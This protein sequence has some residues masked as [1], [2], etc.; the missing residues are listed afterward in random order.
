MARGRPI[1]PTV[2]L[3]IPKR[4][5]QALFRTQLFE[6]GFRVRGFERLSEA[7]AAL[8]RERRPPAAFVLD[9]P[10]AGDAA[11][12]R[13][14]PETIAVLLCLGPF[15][16]ADIYPDRTRL[17]RL[18]KPFTVRDLVDALRNLC[19]KGSDFS[20][21]PSIPPARGAST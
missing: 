6:D 2:F 10:A 16:R 18:L 7:V 13:A 4:T 5:T 21:S 20:G 19:Y 1:R 3:I 15:D 11:A 14:L 17:Q 9:H 12:L 8:R